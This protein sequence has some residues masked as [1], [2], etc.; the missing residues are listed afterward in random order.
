MGGG[1]PFLSASQTIPDAAQAQ[2]QAVET[3]NIT[4][5]YDPAT[6][7]WSLLDHHRS[8]YP[9]AAAHPDHLSRPCRTWD[10]AK[11]STSPARGVISGC[12]RCNSS[13]PQ[14]G[15]VEDLRYGNGLQQYSL[16][17]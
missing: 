10:T 13:H 7:S 3:T 16:R 9:A 2:P 1:T 12:V 14:P 4:Q 17:G 8:P 11:R 5:I 6:D 15:V